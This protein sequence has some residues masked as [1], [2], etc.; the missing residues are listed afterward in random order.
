MI[1]NNSIHIKKVHTDLLFFLFLTIMILF[2]RKQKKKRTHE[3]FLSLSNLINLS[4]ERI[5]E[6]INKNR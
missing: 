1:C 3:V 4:K 6:S 2:L 5:L